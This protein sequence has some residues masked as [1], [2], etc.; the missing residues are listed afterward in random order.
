MTKQCPDC[1]TGMERIRE[2]KPQPYYYC[3]KC[4]WETVMFGV[5]TNGSKDEK[6]IKRICEE[7]E[8]LW[9][10]Y[11]DQRLGQLLLNYVFPPGKKTDYFYTEDD[12]TEKRIIK[13]AARK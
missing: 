9:K 3:P 4:G 2:L 13:E 6:R 10:R 1:K 12:E 8:R 7:L 11:P 5:F